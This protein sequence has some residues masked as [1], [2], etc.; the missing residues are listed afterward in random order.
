MSII[1]WGAKTVALFDVWSI[2]HILVGVSIGSLVTKYNRKVL[3]ELLGRRH[4]VDSWQL[5][6]MGVLC[7]GFGWETMEHYLEIGLA[8]KTAQFWF[9]GVEFWG[10]RLLTDPLM[11]VAGFFIAMRFAKFVIPARVLSLSWMSVHLFV[12]PHSMYLQGM[13]PTL[14]LPQSMIYLIPFLV[15]CALSS[16]Y[17]LK[18]DSASVPTKPKVPRT[19]LS[20]FRR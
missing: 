13:L 11:L 2:E 3:A 16:L 17:L 8:G 15:S 14:S 1:L 18:Y 19:S 9:Q 4:A 20:A 5:N 7:L 12:F 10:N 6:L